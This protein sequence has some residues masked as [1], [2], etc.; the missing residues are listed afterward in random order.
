M[1]FFYKKMCDHFAR[2]KLSGCNAP[3]NVNP[4][5]LQP[6]IC[7]DYAG[8]IAGNFS[9]KVS[10]QLA[11]ERLTCFTVFA[12]RCRAHFLTRAGLERGHSHEKH[13]PFAGT[14]KLFSKSSK[15][16]APLISPRNCPRLGGAGINIVW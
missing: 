4:R 1:A 16:K 13:A 2:L 3:V 7:G 11:W 10:R 12:L 14:F 15:M 8:Q 9:F 6:G 5:L